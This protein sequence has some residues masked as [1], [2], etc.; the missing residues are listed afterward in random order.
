[1]HVH[2]NGRRRVHPISSD[3]EQ[4][5]PQLRFC[6]TARIRWRVWLAVCSSKWRDHHRIRRRS[7]ACLAIAL[8]LSPLIVDIRAPVKRLAGYAQLFDGGVTGKS[9]V[10]SG[11][12]RA[13]VGAR[14]S[15]T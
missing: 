6:V 5:N 4:A 1:M 2:L 13:G 12:S 10:R 11:R 14:P 3:Q 7:V 15:A 9:C 8:R